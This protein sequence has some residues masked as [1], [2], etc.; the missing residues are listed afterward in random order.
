MLQVSAGNTFSYGNEY[1]DLLTGNLSNY[2]ETNKNRINDIHY[3]TYEFFGQDSWKATRK[4]TLELG[5][6]FSHFSPWLDGLG[7][8]IFHL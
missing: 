8:R 5:M 1:A 2:T 6:R 7:F 4:L 3:N